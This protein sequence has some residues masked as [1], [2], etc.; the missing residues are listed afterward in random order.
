M[1]FIKIN[2]VGPRDGLQNEPQL[3]DTTQ[4]VAFI[5]ALSQTGLKYIE[6]TSFVSPKWVPQLADHRE[7]YAQIDKHSGIRY[8]VL[9]PNRKGMQLAI[10]LG[11]TDIAVFTAASEQFTQ[12]NTNCTLAESLDRIAEI[13]TLA[14]QHHMNV[15]GYLSCIIACPYAGDTAP[16]LVAE[17]SAQLLQLGCYEVSL[18]DTIG[19][20][21][22]ASVTTL[23]NHV[24]DTINPELVAMHF[25][26]TNHKAL[27]NIKV[28]LDAG[29][30]SYDAS[31]GGLGGCPYA[32]GVSGNVATETVITLLHDLGFETGVD[33]KKLQAARNL[34]PLNPK[35]KT[36]LR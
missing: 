8:P 30:H 3:I 32:K 16:A 34:L 25:H 33:L 5:N 27:D 23:L 15:R 22:P 26:D 28:S 14:R 29:I 21:T 9:I 4:K 17:I 18:G 1:T 20:G 36:S 6:V 11:V 31:V 19:A 35:T 2:E 12:K 13:I 10:A 7:V 24:L